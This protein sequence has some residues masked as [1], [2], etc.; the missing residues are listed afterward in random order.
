MDTPSCPDFQNPGR[1][2][3][4]WSSLLINA[5]AGFGIAFIVAGTIEI[6]EP[7]MAQAILTGNQ[8]NGRHGS[9]QSQSAEGRHASPG[10]SRCELIDCPDETDAIWK[11][12]E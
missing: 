11:S 6:R 12:V 7:R 9:P 5:M 4:T 10:S 8:Y 3:P 1:H 2:E